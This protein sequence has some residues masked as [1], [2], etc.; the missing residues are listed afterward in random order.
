LIPKVQLLPPFVVTKPFPAKHRVADMHVMMRKRWVVFGTL[1]TFY[2]LP[3]SS[4]RHAA[5]RPFR[6]V[7]A[8]M[9]SDAVE[10]ATSRGH[11]TI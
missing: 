8:A 2:V 7:P 6:A 5:G 9:H 1:D 11:P 4:D 10:Q 3:A